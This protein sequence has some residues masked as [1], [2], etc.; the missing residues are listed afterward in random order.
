MS[1]SFFPSVLPFSALP[2]IFLAKGR[3]YRL[4]ANAKGDGPLLHDAP[5]SGAI[6]LRIGILRPAFGPS[7][8]QPDGH[9]A[10]RPD[11][12]RPEPRQ[13]R[14]ASETTSPAIS[15]PTARSISLT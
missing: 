10:S 11:R 15:M 14:S 9:R 3:P 8:N 7:P 1:P 2:G 5:K 13:R 4:Q 6:R 12:R